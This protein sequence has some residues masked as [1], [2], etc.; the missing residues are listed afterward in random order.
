MNTGTTQSGQLVS[1]TR[2]QPPAKQPVHPC[3]RVEDDHT[4]VRLRGG[5]ILPSFTAP[6]S[7]ALWRLTPAINQKHSHHLHSDPQ[8]AQTQAHR[9]R[10]ILRTKTAS[11]LLPSVY[12]HY[13][14]VQRHVPMLHPLLNDVACDGLVMYEGVV[15]HGLEM[16]RRVCKNRPLS[17]NGNNGVRQTKK[18][19]SLDFAHTMGACLQHGHYYQAKT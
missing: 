6:H 16:M 3:T 7:F 19:T 1:P 4:H 15:E 2:S 12:V 11:V 9:H 5:M 14:H 8:Q 17:D 18:K 10:H 13:F